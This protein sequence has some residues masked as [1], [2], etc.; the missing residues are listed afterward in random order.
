VFENLRNQADVTLVDPHVDSEEMLIPVTESVSNETIESADA[1]VLLVDH[2]V[3]DLTRLG[4]HASF[5]YDAKNAMPQDVSATVVT[6]GEPTQQTATI[7][8][9]TPTR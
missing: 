1:V 3:F 7:I 2:D 9:R 8:E 5:V 6:L 4:E